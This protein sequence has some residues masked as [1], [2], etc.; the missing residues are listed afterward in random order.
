[1]IRRDLIAPGEVDEKDIR[2]VIPKELVG[3]TQCHFFGGIHFPLRE[4]ILSKTLRAHAEVGLPAS[5]AARSRIAR[6]SSVNLILNG[7]SLLGSPDIALRP[8]GGDSL[9]IV[10]T[11][12]NPDSNVATIYPSGQV[13][14]DEEINAMVEWPKCRRC[15]KEMSGAV[16]MR[17]YCS[18]ACKSA[19]RKETG[20][21]VGSVK[22]HICRVCGKEFPI[23][24]GEY[25]KWLCSVKCRKTRNA[26]H[27]RDFHVRKP[28][29]E[30]LY[31]TRRKE[32]QLPDSMQIRFYRVNPHAPRACESCDE[33]R[34]LDVA[35]KPGH[36]RLGDR[37][38]NDRMK[39]PDY[40]WVLCP[41]CHALIDRM[42]YPPHELGLEV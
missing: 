33:N 34:V 9:E 23:G 11:V 13:N 18:I 31:R 42:H 6:S 35:H 32:K 7:R 14:T 22:S 28:Y 26:Q 20:P 40:V 36:E 5:S 3:Y 21:P 37:R 12:L 39:W 16:P 10:A 2:D 1:M 24:P 30:A 15:Q 38:R 25:N 29:A 41:T 4:A 8:I 27:V 19:W 17:K